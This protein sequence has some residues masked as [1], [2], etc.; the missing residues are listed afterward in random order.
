M[1]ISEWMIT[2]N[3]TALWEGSWPELAGHIHGRSR[4]LL[5]AE[6]PR[7]SWH[8]GNWIIEFCEI[9]NHKKTQCCC[10]YSD[11][12]NKKEEKGHIMSPSGLMLVSGKAREAVESRQDARMHGRTHGLLRPGMW[13]PRGVWNP[14]QSVL[15]WV[16]LLRFTG[17]LF[18]VL[19]IGKFALFIVFHVWHLS[20]GQAQSR[21][22]LIFGFS[23][24]INND[25]NIYNP[26]FF[27]ISCVSWQHFYSA[28]PMH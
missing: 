3:H 9:I 20:R 15:S 10:G 25:G 19:Y 16:C 23:F 22:N 18:G 1:V 13:S 7:I 4:A 24:H 14:G 8:W 27:S 11:E 12:G 28:S 5:S 26:V 6:K 2:I 21:Q 17:Y